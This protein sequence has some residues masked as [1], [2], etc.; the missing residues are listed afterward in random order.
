MERHVLEKIK[1]KMTISSDQIKCNFLTSMS[2][3][4]SFLKLLE[5]LFISFG[6]V[7][8]VYDLVASTCIVSSS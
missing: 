2:I 8:V 5:L 1:I 4:W 6:V 3:Y 7:H